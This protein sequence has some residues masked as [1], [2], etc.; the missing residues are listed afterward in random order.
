MRCSRIPFVLAADSLCGECG[1]L[2]RE[3]RERTPARRAPPPH[4]RA[5]D[6]PHR[7]SSFSVAAAQKR[8]Q[9]EPG[10]SFVPRAVR[11]SSGA[12]RAV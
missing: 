3:T 4:G 7:A 1:A 9:V 11:S 10:A 6:V 12:K 8:F 5:I 2:S